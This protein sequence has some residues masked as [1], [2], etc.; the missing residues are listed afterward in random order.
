MERREGHVVTIVT[1]GGGRTMP[2][3][4]DPGH[5]TGEISS[6]SAIETIKDAGQLILETR[7]SGASEG[8]HMTPASSHQAVSVTFY[9]ARVSLHYLVSSVCHLTH[10]SDPG[11]GGHRRNYS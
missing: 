6:P 1:G 4:R 2:G 5:R 10:D 3:T 7:H 11:P 8:G 9:W